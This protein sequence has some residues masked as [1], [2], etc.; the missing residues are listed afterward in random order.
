MGAAVSSMHYTGMAAV[1]ITIA[2][3]RT[4]LDGVTAMDFVF[5]LAVVLGSFLFLASA[6]VALSPRARQPAVTA[7]ARP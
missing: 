1:R 4:A 2:P 5:P 7:T 6:F 3:T